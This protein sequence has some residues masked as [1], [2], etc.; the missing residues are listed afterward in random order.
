[1]ACLVLLLPEE[2]AFSNSDSTRE[3]KVQIARLR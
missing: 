3:Q 2:E 1:M